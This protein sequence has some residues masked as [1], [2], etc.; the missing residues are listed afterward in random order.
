MILTGNRRT[1]N[2]RSFSRS[3][4]RA[5]SSDGAT[6]AT[7]ASSATPIPAQFYSCSDTTTNGTRVRSI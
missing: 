1:T 5:C 3:F 6:R 4:S 7:W 2:S